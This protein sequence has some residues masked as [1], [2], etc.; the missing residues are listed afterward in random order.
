M[1]G[2]IKRIHLHIELTIEHFLLYFECIVSSL[3]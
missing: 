3:E 2:W 1:D